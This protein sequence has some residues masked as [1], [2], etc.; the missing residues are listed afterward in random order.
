ML[1]MQLCFDV[2]S[3]TAPPKP[4]PNFALSGKLIEETNEVNGVLVK[5]TEPADAHKPTRRWR[6]YPFKVKPHN[7]SS[8][9]LVCS[10]LILHCIALQKGDQ[11]LEAIPLHRQ[12]SYLVG[13][14]RLV[15]DIPTDHPS[16]SK[17]HAAIQV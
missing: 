15:A 12:S 6:L 5:Y 10:L 14:D 13:R 7:P 1:L 8:L 4:K 11:A 2:S 3:K 9:I 16:C 17:Q